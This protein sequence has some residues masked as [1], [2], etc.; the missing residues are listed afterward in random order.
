MYY[1]PIAENERWIP[2]VSQILCDR[3]YSSD[4]H[5]DKNCLRLDCPAMFH[6]LKKSPM[7]IHC[8]WS[9]KLTLSW[10]LDGLVYFCDRYNF[11]L[12]WFIKNSRMTERN[13]STALIFL[14]CA[15]NHNN[16]NVGDV[17]YNLQTPDLPLVRAT[18]IFSCQDYCTFI[19]FYSEQ[20][21]MLITR[22]DFVRV[23]YKNPKFIYFDATP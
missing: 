10:L 16:N 4:F 2:L 23:S 12:V 21:R 5:W 13:V 18:L 19:L 9:V 7:L 3:L 6:P 15:S 8:Q 17:N 20:G 22:N 14:R 1:F 11:L